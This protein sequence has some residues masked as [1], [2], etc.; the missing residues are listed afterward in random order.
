MECEN[1]IAAEGRLLC[2][3]LH[4][5][6]SQCVCVEAVSEYVWLVDTNL[7]WMTPVHVTVHLKVF[8]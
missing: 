5:S 3:D 4:H 2:M 7:W 6:V 1:G 8:L